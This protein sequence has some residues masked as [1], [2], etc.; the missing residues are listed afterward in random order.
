MAIPNCFHF[1]HS[2]ASYSPDVIDSSH[3]CHFLT[4]RTFSNWCLYR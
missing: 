3:T 4:H 2:D 1:K